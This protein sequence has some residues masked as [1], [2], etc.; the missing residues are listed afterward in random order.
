MQEY[1]NALR[2]IKEYGVEKADRTGT[3]TI[4]HFGIDMRFDISNS[5]PLVTTKSCHF[6][7]I[8]Y[9]LIWLLSGNTNIKFLQDNNIRIWNE[10]ADENGDLGPVYGKQW[11]SW[12]CSDGSVIDQIQN[13][14]DAI[15][16]NPDSRRILVSAWNVADV[17]HMALPP[18]HLLFQFYV[19]G[20]KLSCK[21]T[22]RSADFFLGV[23]F[24]IASYSLLTYMMAQQCNLEPG[25]F[26]WSGGDCHIY[27]NHLD[28]VN[29][30]LSR[31]PNL[32]PRL[33]LINKPQD[34]FS[35]SYDNFALEDYNPQ[36]KITAKVAV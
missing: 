23:P 1:L 28:Q 33:K 26:I 30:Q 6:K 11:R 24:N 3:G 19:S 21:L 8:A 13:A 34:I 36:P 20:N 25:E 9:E 31:Q 29:E 12:Q 35:Y 5:F 27:Q 4:S 10:W 14:V 16:T 17:A 32:R 18:C 22:Q 2:K 7:S 15:K